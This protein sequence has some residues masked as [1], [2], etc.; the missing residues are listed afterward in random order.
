MDKTALITG[1]TSGIGYELSKIFAREAV[2]LVLVS[3]N[4]Q[5]LKGQKEDFEKRYKVEVCIIAKD[6]S[7]PKVSEE[8]FSDVQSQGIHIDNLVNN[9]G[10]NECGPFYETNLEKEL[11]MLQVHILSLTYL[12]KLFLPGMIKNKYGKILNLGSTGS[13]APCPLDAVTDNPYRTVL[14]GKALFETCD[15]VFVSLP[16]LDFL[17]DK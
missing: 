13:F 2:N 10:F 17:L 14:L 7:E 1:P 15:N 4:G 11:E 16:A 5:K 8:V 3:R 12:T 9:A 6:L